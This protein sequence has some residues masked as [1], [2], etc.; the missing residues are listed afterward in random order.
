MKN[1][2]DRASVRQNT[3]Y[4][5]SRKHAANL[6]RN[7]TLHFQIGLIL[8]LLVTIF[9]MEVRIPETAYKPYEANYDQEEAVW[10]EQFQIE[11][12]VVEVPEPVVDEPKQPEPQLPDELTAVPDDHTIIESVIEGTVEPDVH[13]PMVDPNAGAE[14]VDITDTVEDVPFILIEEVPLFPGCEGLDSNEER[15]DCMSSKIKKFVNKKFDTDIGTELGLQ[16]INKIY[17]QFTVDKTGA[18]TDIQSRAPHD[19]LEEEAK[20]VIQ[21]L[22][23]MQP[24]KQRSVPVGVIYTLPIIFRVQD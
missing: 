8:A 12:R 23:E 18:I 7:P 11:K 9:F 2:Q 22:P 1:S 14:Y 19:K 16:G 21:L 15:K 20:R 6:R 17:V 10:D 13:K 5:A 4:T 24:G 3:E